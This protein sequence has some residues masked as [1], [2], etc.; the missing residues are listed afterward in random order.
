MVVVSLVYLAVQVRQNTE[1][2]RAENFA[3]VLDR[4]SAT[5]SALSRDPELSNLHA[6]GVIDVGLLTPEERIRFTWWFVEAFG[7]F[8][9]IFHQAE[10]GALSEEIWARW[11][12]TIRWWLSYPGVRDW[13]QAN[14]TVFS[15]SFTA[16]VESELPRAERDPARDARWQ[17][18]LTRAQTHG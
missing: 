2:I 10:S 7:A 17:D 4:I 1:S 5:Q 8:E 12:S 18:F 16:F 6:R 15:D 13:W 14:P 11:A 9:F 3:R